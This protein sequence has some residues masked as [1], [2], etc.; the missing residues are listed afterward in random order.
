MIRYEPSKNQFKNYECE[1]S[2]NPRSDGWIIDICE[3]DG[4]LWLGTW[5]GGLIEFDKLQEQYIFYHHDPENPKSLSNDIVFCVYKDKQG[6]LWAGTYGGGLNKFDRKKEQFVS[7][8]MEEGLANNVIYGI[9]EDEFGNL[10]MTTNKGI[11]RF[12]PQSESF[13]NYDMRDG[14]HSKEFNLG[15]HYSNKNGQLLFGGPDGFIGFYP[16][17]VINSQP[18]EVLLTALKKFGQR[19]HLNDPLHRLTEIELS[20]QDDVFSFEFV[21]L[22]YKNPEKNQYA[23]KMEGFDKN[24]NYVGTRREAIYTSLDPGKYTFKVKA[25]NCDGVWNEEGVSVRI[26]ITPPFWKTGWFY[27]I[28]AITLF[29]ITFTL[30]RL[31]IREVLKIER[32]KMEEREKILKK[33]TAD[34]HDELGHRVTKISLLSKIVRRKLNHTSPVIEEQLNKVI[35]NSDRLFREMKE[36]IWEIDP[37]KDSVYDLAVQLKSFSDQLFDD[38]EIAFQVQTLPGK[39][40]NVKLPLLWRQHLQRI[41]KEGMHNILKHASGCRNVLLEITSDD[42]E[43]QFRL[44]ND[45]KGFNPDDCQYGRGIQNMNKRAH[46]INASFSM[47]SKSE[48]G[49][50]IHL[51][52]KLP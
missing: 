9:L 12:D 3:D 34:F 15:A 32:A 31:H 49:T 21:G 35:E 2:P 50:T 8:T 41:L 30:Y 13:R 37:E 29:L 4:I 23:Y 16:E 6:V 22:H 19:V 45:G 7:Y 51:R 26:L 11:S 40:E 38:T 1:L 10:W 46:K 36:F 39:L 18:P 27:L 25:A 43:L 42:D 52:L 33:I 47:D 5:G 48:V 44:T 24:W 14:L 28:A 20:H 17:N